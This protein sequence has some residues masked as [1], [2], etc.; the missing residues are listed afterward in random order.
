[1]RL[2]FMNRLMKKLK[3]ASAVSCLMIF[4]VVTSCGPQFE[5]PFDSDE[6]FA[7]DIELI[8]QYIEDKGYADYDYDTLSFGIRLVVIDQGA[9]SAIEYND[10]VQF[11]YDGR[12]VNDL[13]F[14]TSVAQKAFDQ[15]ISKSTVPVEYTTNENDEVVLD[16]NQLPLIKVIDFDD[17][18]K[19]IYVPS[20]IYTPIVTTHT[21]GDWFLFSQS[22]QGTFLAS[23]TKEAIGKILSSTNIGSKCLILVP[24]SAAYGRSSFG[25]VAANSVVI[26]EIQIK[27]KR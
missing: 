14:D 11:D 24:S 13:L 23:N 15:D 16:N 12:L 19:P 27:R 25:N 22:F 8:E 6:Q 5:D 4:T 20:S 2:K 17:N 10:I 18:Y 21:P 9:G 7:I 1:M 3:L 26:Y